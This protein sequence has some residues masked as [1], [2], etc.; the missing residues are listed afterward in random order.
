MY[1]QFSTLIK[2]IK[3][4]IKIT[5]S[6]AS[7]IKS[8]CVSAKVDHLYL[9]ADGGGCGGFTYNLVPGNLPLDKKDLKV[10]HNEAVV[11]I[12]YLSELNV[13]GTTIDYE[14]EDFSKGI[15][16]SSFKFVPDKEYA[17]SCGCGISFSP[18][19]ID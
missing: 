1:R 17:T 18:R 3:S 7:K 11:Y 12:D 2:N 13:L 4:P 6:A 8:V 19:K 5:D 15:I 9:Y 10:V 16:N 14:K